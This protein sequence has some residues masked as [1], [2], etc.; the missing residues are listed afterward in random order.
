M[1]LYKA[2]LCTFILILLLSNFYPAH[3]AGWESKVNKINNGEKRIIAQDELTRLA[4]KIKKSLSPSLRADSFQT[5]NAA[6]YQIFN[7]LGADPIQ[8]ALSNS[9]ENPK[10]DIVFSKVN[11]TPVSITSQTVNNSLPKKT[12]IPASKSAMALINANKELFRIENPEKELKTAEEFTDESGNS[13]VRLIQ[14]YQG[15]PLWNQEITF[16]FDVSGNM[17]S[18]N[19]RYSPT[20]SNVVTIPE[21]DSAKAIET[22]MN[23]VSSITKFDTSASQF[24][25]LIS[26]PGPLTVKYIWLNQNRSPR[27]VWVVQIRASIRELFNV[28]VDAANGDILQFYNSN[29]SGVAASA[30]ALDVAGISRV[31]NV[32]NADSLYCL[33]DAARPM[34]NPFQINILNDP[35][36]AIWTV[37]YVPQS[38]TIAYNNI[39]SYD[40]SWNDPIAVSAH[41]HAGLVF[42][43]YY[44]TFGRLGLDNNGATIL[45]IVHFLNSQGGPYDNAG[46]SS[47]GFIIYGDGSLYKPFAGGLDVV[48]HELTHG[49]VQYTI[50]LEYM[51]QSGALNESFADIFASMIDRDDW[52]IGEDVGRSGPFRDMQNPSNCG[53]PSHMKDYKNYSYEYD[54]GGVH[55]NSGIP[56]HACYLISTAIGRNKTEKIFYRILQA[57]YLNRQAQFLDMRIAALQSAQDLFGK[58]SI[59]Y[60]AV[61]TAF[62]NVGIIDSEPPFPEPIARGQQQIAAIRY[63]AGNTLSLLNPTY[64]DDTIT[65]SGTSVFTGSSNPVTIPGNGEHVLF[66]DSYNYIR[67]VDLDSRFESAISSSG[68]WSSIASSPD[69]TRVAATTKWADSLIYIFDILN[70]S[71]STSYHLY[72]PYQGR[73]PNSV[74]FAD[75]LDWDIGGRYLVF[76]CYCKINEV[77]GV[78]Q[79]WNVLFLDINTKEIFPVFSEPAKGFSFANPSLAC[80]GLPLFAFDHINQNSGIN[81]VRVTD[82]SKKMLGTIE[83]NRNSLSFP[84]FSSYDSSLVFMRI[85]NGTPCLR[86]IQLDNSKLKPLSASTQIASGYLFPNWFVVGNVSKADDLTDKKI[87]KSKIIVTSNSIHGTATINYSLHLN[88]SINLNLFDMNG[89]LIANLDSGYKKS[90]THSVIWNMRSNRK[91]LARGMYFCRLTIDSGGRKVYQ[92]QPLIISN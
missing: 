35:D 30:P 2:R 82:Y 11:G 33:I 26:S 14:Y 68:I 63:D 81:E 87:I 60:S 64:Y 21:I 38:G 24:H 57:K 42:D 10:W 89:R 39:L 1:L 43:Y 52:L 71:M 12:N 59:E 27:L 8:S 47:S 25:N 6:L 51:F 79:Y 92:S 84:T 50:G 74:L 40:N 13:H 49:V 41:Y 54:N 48:A 67:S 44:N 83:E 4:E 20:P 55:I 31:I 80:S 16:H 88:A 32:Y 69:G 29:P 19:A 7:N 3:A 72:N 45:S 91:S 18:V 75:A 70:P 15:I 34:W 22:A 90:G 62:N 61:R 56:N 58:P 53:Q 78:S 73:E 17:Y 76:D 46:W 28:F 37:S 65:L 36:G 23:K 86:K 9:P 77:S 66:I 5:R 85:E